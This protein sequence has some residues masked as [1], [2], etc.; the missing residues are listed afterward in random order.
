M[1]RPLFL[2]AVVALLTA[3]LAACAPAAAP[4]PTAAP[5]KPAATSAPTARPTEAKPAEAK[6]APTQAAA[7]AAPT[8]KPAAKALPPDYFA[9]KTVKLVVDFSAGGPTDVF[10][11]LVSRHL[12]K[13]IPGK[14]TVVVENMPGAGGNIARNHLYNVA[15]KDGLTIGTFSAVFSNQIFNAPGVQYDAARFE[16]L[17]GVPEASVSLFHKDTGVRTAQDLKNPKQEI[18][19]GGFSPDNS[20]DLSQRSFLNMAGVKYKYVPGYGGVADLRNAMLRGEINYYTDSLT[21]YFTG[22]LQY[23][24]DGTMFAVGHT[25]VLKGGQIVRDPNV[26]DLPTHNEIA[27]IL[28]GEEVKK[29]L[30]YRASAT[31]LKIQGAM[32]RNI[33]L[34]PDT[35]AEVVEVLRKAVSDT[36]A[37]EEFQAEAQKQNAFRLTLIPGAEAAALAR[38]II[39][40][41]D[42]EALDYLQKLSKDQG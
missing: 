3:L 9:G 34:P 26:P 16:W 30:E 14:P 10:A 33:V 1:P 38:E 6:S 31:L 13:Y 24:K 27:V 42:K 28:R 20:K 37:D 8:A 5:P 12:G 19:M 40:S 23:V 2:P 21:G 4:S 41:G 22:E 11:R 15:K 29:T 18:V 32:L 39:G 7:K 17:G 25:G 36:F 35:S